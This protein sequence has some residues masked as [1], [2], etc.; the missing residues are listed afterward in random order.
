MHELSIARSIVD[1]ASEQARG[2]EAHRVVSIRLSLGL[3]SGVV[4]ESLE[5][6][7]PVACE[8]TLCEG[9]ILEVE[10]EPA[11]AHCPSCMRDV[12]LEEFLLVC[13]HCGMYPVEL[14]DGGELKV[15]SMEVE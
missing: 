2:A 9:A 13:P 7:F 12:D 10:T 6:C 15:V 11:R 4:R 5:F 3:L 14:T 8:G 1:L